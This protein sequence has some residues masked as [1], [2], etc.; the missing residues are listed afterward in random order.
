MEQRLAINPAPIWD[1]LRRYAR[2]YP[3]MKALS[4]T[5]PVPLSGYAACSINALAGFVS[6]FFG[7]TIPLFT[8]FSRVI[9]T[10]SSVAAFHMDTCLFG[11]AN[12]KAPS[13]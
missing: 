3:R 13:D 9:E 1:L 10:L 6:G 7:L 2:C 11:L 4:V 12:K 5:L 8:K